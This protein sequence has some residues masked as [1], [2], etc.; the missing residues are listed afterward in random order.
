MGRICIFVTFIMFSSKHAKVVSLKSVD[1]HILVRR[2]YTICEMGRN[3]RMYKYGH[4]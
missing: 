3:S 1:S 2:D 4:S